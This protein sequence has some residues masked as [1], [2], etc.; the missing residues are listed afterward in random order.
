MVLNIAAKASFVAIFGWGL[1][2]TLIGAGLILAGIL[3]LLDF[4]N[5]G[6]RYFESIAIAHSALPFLGQRYRAAQFNHAKNSMG[7]ALLLGGVIFMSLG[8]YVLTAL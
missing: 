1:G 4:R 3:M 8:I 2:L 5:A 6:S 7:A